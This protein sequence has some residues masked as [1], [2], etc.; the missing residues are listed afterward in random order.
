MPSLSSSYTFD[1]FSK[2][3]ELSSVIPSAN[4]PS[5][6]ASACASIDSF[7]H[8]H[9][10]NQSRHFFS[11]AFPTLISKLFGF[12]DPAF[13]NAWIHHRHSDDLA[14]TLFS[15]LSPAGTLAATIVAIDRLSLVK[16]VF[17]T[18]HLPHWTCSLLLNENNV[19]D[20]CPL[21]DLCPS[22]FKP[23][24]SPSQIQL[25]VFEYFFFWFL[26]P[27]SSV[28]L[29]SLVGFG[30]YELGFPESGSW[31]F[32]IRIVWNSQWILCVLLAFVSYR[33]SPCAGNG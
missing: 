4:N 19:V 25:N 27:L 23:S 8:S 21:S 26:S 14:Q 22:L 12:N 2:S 11:L 9:S 31:H 1:S 32:V 20:S 18:K 33:L 13:A 30:L 3:Q 29:V 6:I 5:Q 16:Y 10:P 7:L 15:L 17:P 28:P 24:P